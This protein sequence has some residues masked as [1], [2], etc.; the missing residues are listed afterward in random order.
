MS[1]LDRVARKKNIQGNLF[2]LGKVN[3]TGCIGFTKTPRLPTGA[4]VGASR[5]RCPDTCRTVV[6][7]SVADHVGVG[8]VRVCCTARVLYYGIFV[9]S[10]LLFKIELSLRKIL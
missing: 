1:T 10:V 6:T 8:S 9:V 7:S 5:V 4:D 3:I 2:C